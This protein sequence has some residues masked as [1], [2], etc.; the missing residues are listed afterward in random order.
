MCRVDQADD[1]HP[2]KTHPPLKADGPSPKPTSNSMIPFLVVGDSVRRIPGLS[3]SPQT[4][5]IFH[6]VTLTSIFLPKNA[7]RTG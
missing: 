1:L 4:R 5:K 6:H 7:S 3:M 2:K